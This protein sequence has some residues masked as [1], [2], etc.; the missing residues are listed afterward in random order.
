MKYAPDPLSRR[1]FVEWFARGVLGV[2]LGGAAARGAPPAERRAR[3]DHVIYLFLRGGL[4]HVDTFDP[5]PGREE[6]AGVRAIATSA[7]GVQVS[8]WFPRLARRMH[9]VA[10]V[11]SMTSTQGVHERGNYLAHTAFFQTPTITHPTLGAW[12][13]RLLGPSAGGLPGNILI[14]G[15]PQHPGAGFLGPELAPLPVIDPSAGLPD[16]RPAAGATAGTWR[17]AP[18]WRTTSGRGFSGGWLGAIQP[19]TGR[20]GTRPAR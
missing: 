8:E 7:D 5:K 18:R 20:C 3:A 9:H 13:L 15:S 12:A 6:M 11:R 2:K 10:L 17:A 19:P 4:S 16:S 14:N 1:R